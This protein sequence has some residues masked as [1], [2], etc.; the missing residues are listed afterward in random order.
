[1]FKKL[2]DFFRR[3]EPP[4]ENQVVSLDDLPGWLDTREEE[5]RR[6]LA[7]ATA[8]SR[9][10]VSS[11]LDHLRE[12]IGRMETAEG[13]EG[14]HPR[15]QDISRK[16]L[17]Q[18]T[19]SMTQIL[20]RDLPDEPE[21]FYAT[22]AD[23]LKSALKTMKGQG[24]YLAS[25]YPEEMKEVRG[26]IRDLGRAINAMTGEVGTALRDREQMADIREIC[27]SLSRTREEY[28]AVSARIQDHTTA[29]ERIE[30]EILATREDLA[31]LKRRPD[32]AQK[33]QI[34]AEIR[35]IEAMAR[36]T[37]NLAAALQTTATRIF[38]KA[39]KA[40]EKAGDD[41]TAA[42]LALVLDDYSDPSPDDADA[43]ADLTRS[44]MP[45][46]L[47][48]V[49]RGDLPLKNQEEIHLFSDQDTLP[50]EV[51]TVLRRQKEIPERHAALQATYAALPV[52]IE[53]ERLTTRLSDLQRERETED[54]ARERALDQQGGLQ[55]SYAA[56]RERLIAHR[57]AL[58][59]QGVEVDV[60]DLTPP[61]LPPSP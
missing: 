43:L 27:E 30:Q 15:L 24:R 59:G 53:E 31:A 44:V 34:E 26:A 14:V 42:E 49:R 17:P 20:S 29:I 33:E 57:T 48:M 6:D 16:A 28:A 55:A 13:E 1:M 22:A 40:A 5:I 25:L 7:D 60:P 56:E 18:F 47:A 38:R 54:T 8:P 23:I 21:E 4:E 2:R 46:I 58:A 52:V 11:A 39:G 51:R 10:A 3:T 19:K 50:D 36:E 45:A 35:E 12:V 32:Y 9:E 37:R 61:P 41:I